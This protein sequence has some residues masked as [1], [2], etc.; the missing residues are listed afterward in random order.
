MGQVADH[1][2]RIIRTLTVK[3]ALVGHSF[4][5]LIVQML[6]GRAAAAATVAIDP[7]PFRG[8]LPLR[9]RLSSLGSPSWASAAP[10]L[11]GRSPCGRVVPMLTTPQLSVSGD[12]GGKPPAR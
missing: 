5:G 7:A 11:E 4:G 6:A 10:D 3:P 8:V 12:A 9:S 2:Q 1:Y